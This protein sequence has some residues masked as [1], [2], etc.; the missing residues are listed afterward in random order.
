[1]TLKELQKKYPDK[2]FGS[3]RV[4]RGF[5][6]LPGLNLDVKDKGWFISAEKVFKQARKLQENLDKAIE[7]CEKNPYIYDNTRI[8][9][10]IPHLL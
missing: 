5:Q 1:M 9:P 3:V 8:S 4:R 10:K 7:Y 6:F 2:K